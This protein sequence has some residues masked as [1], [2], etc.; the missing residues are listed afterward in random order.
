MAQLPLDQDPT[1]NPLSP[2]NPRAQSFAEAQAGFAEPVLSESERTIAR[3]D[4]TVS[5]GVTPGRSDAEQSLEVRTQ[6][7]TASAIDAEPLPTPTLGL[8]P[9]V[10]LEQTTPEELDDIQKRLEA[11]RKRR[12]SRLGKKAPSKKVAGKIEEARLSNANLTSE[13]T[14]IFDLFGRA[15]DLGTVDR[16]GRFDQFINNVVADFGLELD[17]KDSAQ[18]RAYI[19]FTRATSASLKRQLKDVSGAAVTESERTEFLRSFPDGGSVSN[20]FKGD[21]PIVFLQKAVDSFRNMNR[22][23]ARANFLTTRDGKITVPGMEE[24]NLN[25]VDAIISTALEAAPIEEVA[26]TFGLDYDG[27]P[28]PEGVDPA[29]Y[30]LTGGQINPDNVA[31]G[32]GAAPAEIAPLR[33]VIQNGNRFNADTGEFLGAQ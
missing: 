14:E 4:S 1:N 25:E 17:P 23:T 28:I 9:K 6:L 30:L 20:P 13:F 8:Q 33:V 26:K 2:S 27:G 5:L 31:P 24:V 16:V 12:G 19:S 11:F 15:E 29:E 22:A 32:G 3:A 10:E 18:L 21:S 7:A